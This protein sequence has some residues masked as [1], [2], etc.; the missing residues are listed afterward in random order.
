MSAHSENAK[1]TFWLLI[2]V[3]LLLQTILE[4]LAVRSHHWFDMLY[5]EFGVLDSPTP[6]VHAFPKLVCSA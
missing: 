4:L 2:Q 6:H 5:W 1:S 3:S